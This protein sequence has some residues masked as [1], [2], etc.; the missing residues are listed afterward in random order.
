MVPAPDCSVLLTTLE[1][2]AR[3]LFQRFL[4]A[5]GALL[6]PT[7]AYTKAWFPC[8]STE[9]DCLVNDIKGGGKALR[10]LTGTQASCQLSMYMMAISH[11]SSLIHRLTCLLFDPLQSAMLRVK[12]EVSLS[13]LKQQ[14]RLSWYTLE[15]HPRNPQKQAWGA[16][17]HP[18]RVCVTDNSV[19]SNVKAAA[20][21]KSG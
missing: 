2:E 7:T 18:H 16:H 4:S 11:L 6:I 12:S 13:H 21:G 8:S 15:T 9:R 3:Y 20:A 5:S 19:S 17:P 14:L 1:D 10:G